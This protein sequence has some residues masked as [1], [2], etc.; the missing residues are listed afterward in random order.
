MARPGSQIDKKLLNT[1]IE[2]IAQKGVKALSVRAVCR[3]ANVNLGL[4]SY[5]F[6]NKDTYLKCLFDNIRERLIIFLDMSQAETLPPIQRFRYCFRRMLTFAFENKNLLRAVFVECSLDQELYRSYIA[7]GILKPFELPL[8][9]IRD[10]QE[11]GSIRSDLSIGQIQGILFFGALMP[12]LFSDCV[13]ILQIG[14]QV[15]K[16]DLETHLN[17][18][19]ELFNEVEKK[20]AI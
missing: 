20:H 7:K 14:G 5:F 3:I 10:A 4:F 8:T 19:E 16:D 2:L 1:G 11:S 6:K 12:I 13:A 15:Q 17:R 18:L 9:V